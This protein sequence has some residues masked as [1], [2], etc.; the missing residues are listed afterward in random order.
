MYF[1]RHSVPY[2]HCFLTIIDSIH[3][4]QNG[5][6]QA[7]TN[8]EVGSPPS[9]HDMHAGYGR[10]A[11][12]HSHFMPHIS[13]NSPSRL[14]QQSLPRF[15]HVR[16]AVRGSEWNHIKIQPPQSSFNSGAPLSPGNSSLNNGMPWGIS[17]TF[18][19]YFFL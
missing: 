17:F 12:K 11:S 8:V 4:R 5:P 2:I 6:I 9:A 14:G 16:P 3:V 15:N 19:R 18:T 10:S 1:W 7:F 13:Q